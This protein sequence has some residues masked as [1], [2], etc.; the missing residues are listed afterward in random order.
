MGRQIDPNDEKYKGR[1]AWRKVAS[2]K[3]ER[4]LAVCG[5]ERYAAGSGSRMLSLRMLCLK[6]FSDSGE[7]NTELFENFVI[8]DTSLWRF[9]KLPQAIGYNEP[10][11]VDDDEDLGKVITFGY[12]RASLKTD[13]FEYSN[14]V[15]KR[16]IRV[17]R[18]KPAGEF[19]EDPE[20]ADWIE[21]G[22][23]RHEEYLRWRSE[24]PRGARAQSSGKRGGYSGG[25]RSSGGGSSPGSGSSDDEIPF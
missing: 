7:E 3:G 19:A 5:F 24:N 11:D 16:T 14:G 17:D 18:F 21:A 1:E 8:E 13:V 12:V 6:D 15:T 20:W 10:F 9:M 2:A 25:G 22:E 4:L 23:L